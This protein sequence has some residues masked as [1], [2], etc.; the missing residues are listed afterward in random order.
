[1]QGAWWL[2]HG[3]VPVAKSLLGQIAGDVVL[4]L[5]AVVRSAGGMLA[6]R[7]VPVKV[8]WLWSSMAIAGAALCACSASSTR[9]T[10][11]TGASE[12]SGHGSS[13]ASGSAP[14]GGAIEW[15]LSPEQIAS[16]CR[17]ELG[18]ARARL[19]AILA[20]PGDGQAAVKSLVAIDAAVADMRDALIAQT[21]LA[22]VDDDEAVRGASTTCKE[23]LAAFRVDLAANPAVYQ[24]ATAVREQAPSPVDRRLAQML[25]EAGRASGVGLAPDRRAEVTRL[26][27][28]LNKL[29]LAYMQAFR[30]TAT[31]IEISRDEATGLDPAFVKTLRVT[32]NGYQ[33]PVGYSTME[34]F[35]SA[36][37]SGQARERYW[38]AF[39]N[40]GGQANVEL[41][42]RALA[43]RHELARALGFESWAAYRLDSKMAKT[44]KRAMELLQDVSTTL[45]P[46][47]RSEIQELARLKASLGDKT[48][49]AP[50]DYDYYQQ[51]FS[52][53]RPGVDSKSIRQ[54][55]PADKVIPAVL[56]IYEKLFGV[57]FQPVSPARVWEPSVREM[58]ISESASGK[59]I[60]R[61]Y[62]DLEPRPSKSLHFS[63]FRLRS[64]RVLA[65]GTYQ[66]PIAAIIGNGPAAEPGQPALFSHKDVIIFFHELGHL[67]HDTLSTAPYATLYGTN[68]RRDFAE[69]PSQML[70][71]WAWQPAVLKKISSHV[72]SQEPLPDPLIEAMVA[73]KHRAVGAFWTRQAFF[74]IY[75][76]KIHSSGPKVDTSQLWLDLTVELTALPPVP[77]TIPQASFAGFMGGYDAGYYGYI[78]SKVYAQDMF[79]ELLRGGLD[80]PEVGRRYRREVLEPGGTRE[81]DELLERFLGRPVSFE[82]FYQDLGMSK[83]NK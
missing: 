23:E 47:A 73:S 49:F 60:A 22:H 61:I 50:W 71:N 24:L 38:M 33:V 30:Q 17:V 70:E 16:S 5:S 39:Y 4:G 28:E 20:R 55:F 81:P 1:M 31:T 11:A 52:H 7:E 83:G 40:R 74:A 2:Q 76:M 48:P 37:P 27:G 9:S 46:I 35:L 79:S 45:L 67:V 43:L 82:A 69:A 25:I 19:Q 62:L 53:S 12:A 32:A 44:P 36:Q 29:E 51:R 8:Y 10:G 63:F 77:G 26:F 65:D 72:V 57:T 21:L 18:K 80:N 68:V 6:A 56:D 78:W 59:P 13:A 34:R 54:Y 41:L 64:G 66:Q 15:Q 75:D 3:K 42:E 14:A 58:I